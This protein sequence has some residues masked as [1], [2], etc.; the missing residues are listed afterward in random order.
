MKILFI[1]PY[2]GLYGSEIYLLNIINK[3][4]DPDFHI[5]VFCKSPTGRNIV[6]NS[7]IKWVNATYNPSS[8]FQRVKNK[9]YSFLFKRTLDEGQL[10]RVNKRFK[11]DVWYIN[12]IVMPNYAALAK[13]INQRYILQIHEMP[14]V[15]GMM[16]ENAF[17]EMVTGASLIITCSKYLTK[18][19]KE[20]KCKHVELL[21]GAIDPSIKVDEQLRN[22]IRSTLNIPEN[23]FV[24]G[25]AGSTSY[26]KGFD[27]FA[28]IA[29]LNQN[30]Q[31]HFLW[32][33]PVKDHG[34]EFFVKSKL[35][36]SKLKNVHL[37]GKKNRIDF[38][39]YLNAIDGFLLTSREDPFPLVMIEAG[40]LGKPII[41]FDS[42]GVKEFV[43]EGTGFI[44]EGINILEMNNYMNKVMANQKLIDK[45]I[46]VRN[47]MK[48]N[49]TD[50]I[51][52]WK[53]IIKSNEKLLIDD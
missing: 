26:R 30:N 32:I 34:F 31:T 25:M 11:P 7:R 36:N 33:G 39:N 48:Y 3:I 35:S 20:L 37:V 2:G 21:Y 47:A 38:F 53:Q 10:L 43:V 5:T 45:E 9:L 14:S 19:F 17:K 4:D 24:W 49:L 16:K 8:F 40:Y 15:Y 18:T 28:D 23:A 13:R 41:A 6:D 27:L 51:A 22:G 12:T 44:T 42:G 29:A 46:I 52:N 1:I 50:Q